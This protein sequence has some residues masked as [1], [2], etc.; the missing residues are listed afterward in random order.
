MLNTVAQITHS[1]AG[2]A[3]KAVSTPKIHK[4]SICNDEGLSQRWTCSCLIYTE[5]HRSQQPLHHLVPPSTSAATLSARHF[6]QQPSL[7]ELSLS[8]KV[9]H[10]WLVR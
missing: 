7:V 8:T 3:M 2:V 5:A 9:C 4:R 10:Y 6:A 1:K